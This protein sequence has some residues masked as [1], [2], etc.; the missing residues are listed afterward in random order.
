MGRKYKSTGLRGFVF[1]WHKQCDVKSAQLSNGRGVKVGLVLWSKYEGA[2][3]AI[4]RAS[5]RHVTAAR[6]D[7]WR[8]DVSAGGGPQTTLS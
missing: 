2:G 1:I 3:D 5:R 8:L 6:G 7:R 4:E